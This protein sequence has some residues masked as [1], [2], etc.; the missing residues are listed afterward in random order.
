VTFDEAKVCDTVV[1]TVMAKIAEQLRDGKGLGSEETAGLK[2]QV[3]ALQDEKE[4]QQQV[5]EEM[6]GEMEELRSTTSA[7]VDEVSSLK[8]ENSKLIVQLAEAQ[9][10]STIAI[11]TAKE[12]AARAAGLQ[13][14][15]SDL[16]RQSATQVKN[17]KAAREQLERHEMKAKEMLNI[18]QVPSSLL[19]ADLDN[20]KDHGEE[21]A[22]QE[23]L[24]SKL[25]E[26][27]DEQVEALA[28]AFQHADGDC[29]IAF[30]HNAVKPY[31]V[32]PPM[33][34]RPYVR[35]VVEVGQ[36]HGPGGTAAKAAVVK[37]MEQRAIFRLH[38]MPTGMVTSRPDE[39]YRMSYKIV[40]KPE[41]D[42][43]TATVVLSPPWLPAPIYCPMKY[44]TALTCTKEAAEKDREARAR[45][46]MPQPEQKDGQQQ[47]SGQ[48]TS[49]EP[50]CQG[51]APVT[52]EVDEGGQGSGPAGGEALVALDDGHCERMMLDT[53]EEAAHGELPMAVVTTA[54]SGLS[55]EAMCAINDNA[56]DLQTL[57]HAFSATVMPADTQSET[58]MAV[59][60]KVVK[61]EQDS[62]VGKFQL[63]L[64]VAG[65][66]NPN[67]LSNSTK[68]RPIVTYMEQG[69]KGRMLTVMAAG[70]D[71]L[72][73]EG[74]QPEQVL[75][76]SGANVDI[77]TRQKAQE[78]GLKIE[79]YHSSVQTSSGARCA[80]AGIVRS[81]TITLCK[82]D[83][84]RESS[85]VTDLTVLD[86][87]GG[88]YDLLLGT[89]FMR[90]AGM[91]MDFATGWI[92]YRVNWQQNS[93][94]DRVQDVVVI[95]MRRSSLTA[96][97]MMA[98]VSITASAQVP[99]SIS[100][101]QST[102]TS[103]TPAENTFISAPG[104]YMAVPPP[105]Q[106]LAQGEGSVVDLGPDWEWY[107]FDEC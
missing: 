77:I 67:L 73:G 48:P 75:V 99:S 50:T 29:V 42:M 84:L 88:L 94:W 78:H 98:P 89:P 10:N 21:E 102:Q 104:L 64:D 2:R 30:T 3:A 6:Q 63:Q 1:G 83:P 101:E 9:A 61:W 19:E 107:T 41:M 49:S 81:V 23:Q 17:Y 105:A 76:D 53:E 44:A 86:A 71:S 12:E 27:S 38:D 52:G 54:S 31:V 33:F 16:V 100:Q 15:R 55:G 103:V 24:K 13:K 92:G 45:T 40:G 36:Q 4:Q 93:T 97:S 57:S 62:V 82:G 72:S 70:V 58:A 8:A 39:I 65:V 47:P 68:G 96:C 43:E 46:A 20:V 22:L 79:P 90:A 85:V 35:P 95:P 32:H 66:R 25:E 87:T 56:S 5:L 60:A 28:A 51:A 106:L 11:A 14:L 18:L 26:C 91:M 74:Y 7:A 59:A 37:S 34:E 80:V 69:D